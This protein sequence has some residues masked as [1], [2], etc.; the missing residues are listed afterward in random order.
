VDINEIK[1][2]AIYEQVGLYM[3]LFDYNYF[4]YI[5]MILF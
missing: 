4:A 2:G 5:Y 3:L 1:F